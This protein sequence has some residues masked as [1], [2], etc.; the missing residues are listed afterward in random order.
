MVKTIKF[1]N[2]KLTQKQENIFLKNFKNVLRQDNRIQNN[3]VEHLEK[4][5][6]YIY[7]CK[8]AIALNSCTDA[9]IFSIRSFNF[10]PGSEI[11]T[12]PLTWFSTTSAIVINNLKPVFCNIKEDMNI[13][14][15]QIEHFITKKTVAILPVHLNGQICDVKKLYKICKKYNLKLIQDCAQSFGSKSYNFK[16]SIKDVSCFSFHPSKIIRSFRDSGALLTNSKKIYEKVLLLRNHGVE[17]RFSYKLAGFNSRMDEMSANFIMY[18]LKNLNKILKIRRL[19]AQIYY[20]KIKKNNVKFILEKDKLNFNNFQFFPIKA[21]RPFKL[22][23]HLNNQKIEARIY[24]KPL[25]D[26]KFMKNY[27]I[28]KKINN[29]KTNILYLPI[30]ENLN[31]KCIEYICREINNFYEKN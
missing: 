3:V 27:L 17:G 9:L 11:I 13:D 23:K 14:E 8:Y 10:K 15:S 5:L 16:Y 4:K 18:Y 7:N 6:R 21:S 1:I 26:S 25:N 31:R 29:K 22:L 30:N 12:T 28:K 24:F 20:K 2:N 19:F